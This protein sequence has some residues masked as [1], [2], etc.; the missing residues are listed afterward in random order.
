MSIGNKIVNKVIPK[1]GKSLSNTYF[2]GVVKDGRSTLIPF[3]INF[4]Q[5]GPAIVADTTQ[6]KSPSII[7]LPISALSVAAMAIAAGCGGNMQ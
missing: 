2:I 7:T 1:A 5:I 3:L 6:T 4:V